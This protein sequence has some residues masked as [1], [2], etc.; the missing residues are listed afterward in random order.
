M[1]VREGERAPAGDAHPRCVMARREV[2]G[3]EEEAGGGR[4]SST[5]LT[6]FQQVDAAGLRR[7]KLDPKKEKLIFSLQVLTLK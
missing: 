4:G 3:D 6:G 5:A 1:R 2:G 7:S